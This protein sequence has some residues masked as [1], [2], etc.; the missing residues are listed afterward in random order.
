MEVAQAMDHVL[1]HGIA[2]AAMRRLF[3]KVDPHIND[4][5]GWV[6]ERLGEHLWS[7]QREIAESVRD[8][9][10]TAVESAH[11]TGKSF[12]A[13]RLVAWWLESHAP[14]DAFAVTTAP[15][16]TQVETILW[17]EIG[18][19]HTKGNLSGRITGGSVPSWKRSTGEIVGYG[20]KPQDLSNQ[21]EAAAAFSG[22][23]ARFVLVI[24]DEADGIPRWLWDAVDTLATNESARVLAIGNPDAPDSHFAKV[25]A[26]GSGWTVHNISAFDTPAFT[27]ERVP[28]QLLEVLVSLDW[29]QERAHRWGVRS[30][31]YLSKVLGQRPESDEHT[32]IPAAEV[33]AAQKRDLSGEMIDDPGRYGWDIARLGSDETVG[34]LNRGGVVRRVYARHRQTTDVTTGDI[35]AELSKHPLRTS[36]VDSVGVG[37]GV[38]D[39]LLAQG[40]QV[41]GFEAGARAGRHDRFIDQRAEAWWSLRSLFEAGLVDI[42]PDDDELAA[43]LQAPRWWRE[44]SGRM[45]LEPK[46]AMA[47]RGVASPDRADAVVMSFLRPVAIVE[48]DEPPD[49]HPQ[50]AAADPDLLPPDEHGVDPY[51]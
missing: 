11:D 45:R 39:A 51:E 38:F 20:R 27:G 2:D 25:A 31:L 36:K 41:Q 9:R 47:K 29:V 40:H 50:S 22:I 26:P 8:N 43:Q 1:P 28:E 33:R 10:Y 21:E 17:R 3:P 18:R 42:D 14:G 23:H 16:Q 35:A 5:V 48:E 34:Y 32:I 37:A 19:A 13:S 4:P 7:R 30:S 24:L 44:P 6:Q 12:I 49:A 46:D 15:T